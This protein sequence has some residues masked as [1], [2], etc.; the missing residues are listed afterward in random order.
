MKI[1]GF[2]FL[3]LILAAPLGAARV[4]GPDGLVIEEVVA[5]ELSWIERLFGTGALAIATDKATYKPGE[6]VV[7]DIAVPVPCNTR[8]VTFGV[9]GP[10]GKETTLDLSPQLRGACSTYRFTAR[11]VAPNTVGTHTMFVVMRDQ[12]GL[13]LYRE[14]AALVIQ[15]TTTCPTGY[16]SSW[17]NGQVIENGRMQ[18]MTCYHYAANTC[19]QTIYKQDRIVCNS[20]YENVGSRCVPK[21]A[22]PVCGD[23]V[24]N[25]Q[26]VCDTG[27]QNGACPAS[28]SLTCTR[29][30]CAAQPVPVDP[31]PPA[32]PAGGDGVAA[33]WLVGGAGVALLAG[34][35]Y[36]GRKK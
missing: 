9:R 5:D 25:G 23:G 6:A 1:L 31:A 19:A 36:V 2:L 16:C 7:L 13:E 18:S 24:V 8:T 17:E 15:T 28:C 21:T 26:E 20:G 3:A 27:F 30:T 10:D 32:P 22:A 12:N 33:W 29:N 35:W 4:E 34:S 14:Q 11:I